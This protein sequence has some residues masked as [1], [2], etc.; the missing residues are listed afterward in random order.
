MNPTAISRRD[1]MTQ[2]RLARQKGMICEKST[3][4][5]SNAISLAREECRTLG[6]NGRYPKRVAACMKKINH[7][8]HSRNT[9]H[10]APKK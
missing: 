1:Q 7:P 2:K 8:K 9:R 5:K 4:G 10:V 3:S 6:E